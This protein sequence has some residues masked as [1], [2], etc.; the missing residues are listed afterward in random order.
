MWWETAAIYQIYPRSFQDSNGDGVGDLPGI[1]SRLDHLVEIGVDALWLSPIYPSPLAD[2]GYDVSDH[3][4]IDPVYGT[5][6]DFD[7]LVEEAERRG[8]RVLLD[9]VPC[10][11]SIEHPWFREHPDWYV[12]AEARNGGPPNNWSS[13]FGGPAW[14]YDEE[15]GLWYLHSFYPEQPDLDWRNPEVVEAMQEVVRFWLERGAA[16]YRIDAVDRLSKD[17]E[18]RDDPSATEPF[19]LPLRPDEARFALTMSRNGPYTGAALGAIRE[20]AGDALLVGEIYLPSSEWGPYLEHLDVAFAFEL[21]HSPWDARELGRAI[22]ITAPVRGARGTAA[23][24]V[25]SNHD[26]GRLASRYGAENARAALL[27]LLTLPGVAFL[28][29]GDEIGLGHGPGADPPFD[30]AGRDPYR[31][32]MQWDASPT[33][34]FTDGE[35]WLPLVD[36]ADRNV[37][38]QRGDPGSTLSLCKRLLELRRGLSRGFRLLDD[39]GEDVLAYGRGDHV[40]AVNTTARVL[41]APRGNPVLETEPEAASGGKLAPHAG[42]VLAVG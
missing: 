22:E 31:H 33:G 29:Q 34:G 40:L 24:W 26:F 2:F 37:A 39:A 1:T 3:T 13:A 27:L 23:A 35:P 12:W 28:Y 8:L 30:R 7:R 42:A 41:P 38:D 20:A 15:R 9:L 14:T 18:L 5:L 32:P 19:G 21:L 6:D 10:H 4:A 17:P 16:G 36:P 11:T 25:M